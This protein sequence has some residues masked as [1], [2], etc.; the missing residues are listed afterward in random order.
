[1]VGERVALPARLRL[2]HWNQLAKQARSTRSRASSIS[3]KGWR[4]RLGPACRFEEF[5]LLEM[6]C[7]RGEVVRKYCGMGV[8]SSTQALN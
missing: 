8:G 3:R 4:E 7:A 2:E 1:M 5:A 6:R